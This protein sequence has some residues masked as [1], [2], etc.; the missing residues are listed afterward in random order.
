MRA[1]DRAADGPTLLSLLSV[2]LVEHRAF[3]SASA[4]ERLFLTY[5]ARCKSRLRARLASGEEIGLFLERGTIL[6]GGD[7]LAAADG[8]VVEVIASEEALMETRSAD[9]LLLARVAYHLGNRHVAVQ[10]GAGWLRF[11]SDHVLSEMVAGLGLEV[12]AINAPFEPEAGAYAS[13][14]HHE[15]A[16]PGTSRIHQYRSKP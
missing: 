12:T 16:N 7:K 6:R 2:L 8:R 4:D 11:G 3:S 15:H 14:H 5:E 1:R 10:L 9:P 13:A